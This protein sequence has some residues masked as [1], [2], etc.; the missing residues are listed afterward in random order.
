MSRPIIRTNGNPAIG[1][2]IS[3]D[4]NTTD[5]T[6]SLNYVPVNYGVW[7]ASTWDSGAWGGT[8]QVLQNWQGLNGVGYYG[9]PTVKVVSNKL[10]VRWV[11]TD[12][13]IESGAIL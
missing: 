6:S 7:D 11:S 9:A 5:T 10:E 12:I 1:A 13:V 3:I 4:F 8:L 2:G